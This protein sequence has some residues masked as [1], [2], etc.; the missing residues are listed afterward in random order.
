MV[1]PGGRAAAKYTLTNHY[2]YFEKGLITTNA[3]QVPV[4]TLHDIDVRQSMTQKAR[5]VGDVVVQFNRGGVAEVVTLE[6]IGDFRNV[7]RMLN[8]VSHAARLAITKMENT[9]HYGDG[10]PTFQV[11]NPASTP[12][13]AATAPVADPMDQLRKLG[14]LRD[15]GVLSEAEFAA[16]KTEILARM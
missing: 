9:R 3:Q 14:D 7:Q 1:D 15:A 8:E 16:K 10:A 6:S 13:V 5:G 11:S 2:L 12:P 4:S